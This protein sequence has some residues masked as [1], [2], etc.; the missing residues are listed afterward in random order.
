MKKLL[1]AACLLMTMGGIANA[2]TPL[3]T[4]TKHDITKTKMDDGSK[5][6]VSALNAK[7]KNADGSKVKTG[8]HEQ[9]TKSELNKTKAKT[10]NN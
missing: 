8:N 4:K 9:K 5:T 2:Q 3:K 6:K 10:A 1:F 7:T